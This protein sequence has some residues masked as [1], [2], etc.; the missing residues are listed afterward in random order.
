M[1]YAQVL[2][3]ALCATALAG[4]TPAAAPPDPE[5]GPTSSGRFAGPWADLFEL[6]YEQATSDDERAALDDSEIS[7]E[8][9]AYFQDKIVACLDGI[10]VTA[11][12]EADGSLNY[13]KPKAVSADAVRDCNADNGIRVIGLH[14][15]VL[16]NPTHLD[17][18]EIMLDCLRRADVV[19]QGY[20]AA[21]LDNGVDMDKISA[22]PAFGGCVDDPLHYDGQ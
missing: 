21:D 19:G 22:D 9:Y 3:I 7:P 15:A 12:F 20:T 2:A 10:G 8:E 6:T 11:H 1:G 4:C 18:T 14:D 13:T 16:R 5:S 17:E